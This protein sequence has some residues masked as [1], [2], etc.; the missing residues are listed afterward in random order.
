M[1]DVKIK[2]GQLL[3]SEPSFMGENTFNRSVLILTEYSKEGTVGFILNKPL[4]FS[5]GDLI[6]EINSSLTVYNGGPVE[7]DNLYFIH[8]VPNKIKDSIEISNGIFWGGDFNS[9][10][11]LLNEDK[12]SKTEIRFFLGYTGWSKEQLENEIK[13]NSWLV[14]ENTE[15]EKIL[16]KSS[17]EFWKEKIKSLGGEY[18]LFSNAPENPILN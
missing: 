15:K 4:V 13:E 7:Q 6:P 17:S 14:I 8:T 2:K 16:S 12:I 11:N 9:L 3:L 5:I 1:Q 10:I 18:I